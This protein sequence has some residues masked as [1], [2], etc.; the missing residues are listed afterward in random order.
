MAMDAQRLAGAQ[1]MNNEFPA[2]PGQRL[3]PTN[4]TSVGT[5]LQRLMYASPMAPVIVPFTEAAL[6]ATAPAAQP[7][8][9]LANPVAPG[10]GLGSA[11]SVPQPSAYLNVPYG[12][13]SGRVTADVAP[14]PAPAAADVAPTTPAA[15]AVQGY[16]NPVVNVEPVG[17]PIGMPQMATNY[18]PM[19]FVSNYGVDALDAPNAS[20][21]WADRAAQMVVDGQVPTFSIAAGMAQD[22]IL[23]RA[24]NARSAANKGYLANTM[25][26]V[27]ADPNFR[28]TVAQ[29]M[30]QEGL[31]YNLAYQKALI[32]NANARGAYQVANLYEAERFAPAVDAYGQRAAT[33]AV[34]TGANYNGVTGW[35]GR[36]I[37]TGGAAPTVQ[38]NGDGTVTVSDGTNAV[39]YDGGAAAIGNMAT[40]GN[41][42][43]AQS[44][45]ATMQVLQQ[46]MQA[47]AARAQQAA[48]QAEAV[49]KVEAQNRKAMTDMYE[50]QS[51]LLRAPNQRATGAGGAASGQPSAGQRVQAARLQLQQ[52]AAMRQTD[53]DMAAQ[54]ERQALAVLS[55]IGGYAPT[56]Q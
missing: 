55:E 6:Q 32:A 27:Q 26:A 39:T 40:W 30:E 16:Q 38:Q 5:W 31:P 13:M 21:A 20:R 56:T 53:P 17:T 1:A 50:V 19:R 22:R 4:G 37:R 35:D 54:L 44:Q 51:R 34:E 28:N 49:A 45:Q 11:A 8:V 7:R 33:S 3:A 24:A 2:N 47:N 29:I 52:A 42:T 23:A 41:P 48:Q 46:Q 36:V 15:P 10:A 9:G 12:T 14:S 25:A 18:Q 43:A